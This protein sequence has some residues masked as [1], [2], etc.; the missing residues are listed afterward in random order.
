MRVK[1]GWIVSVAAAVILAGCGSDPDKMERGIASDP[2]VA[3]PQSEKELGMT[4]AERRAQE[5][6]DE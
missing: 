2:E 5:E 4:E 3:V 6:A 1:S